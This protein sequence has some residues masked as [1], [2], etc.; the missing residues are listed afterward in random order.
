MLKKHFLEILRWGLRLHGV[1][2]FIEVFSAIT[3]GAY[4]TATIAS[5]FIF[6]EILASF[7]IP[8]EHVHLKPLK[9]DIHDECDNV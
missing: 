6:L 9:S 4:I 1:G 2:H 8:K 5:F 3:E 7:Y